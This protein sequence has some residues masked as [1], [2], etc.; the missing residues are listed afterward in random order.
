MQPGAA[1][2][3]GPMNPFQSSSGQKAGCNVTTKSMFLELTGFNPHPARR[4]DATGSTATGSP[5]NKGFNPHPARR[6]DA[7]RRLTP[8]PTS[9]S[10][11]QSSSGQKAGCN[12][13]APTSTAWPPCF[14]PHPARRPDATSRVATTRN[15]ITGFNPHPARRPD[16][17]R[18]ATTR[19]MITVFQS[20]S[21]QKAGCN[22]RPSATRS[23]QEGVSILIRPEGRMQPAS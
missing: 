16:A 6:P 8:S 20:S 19:N 2:T 10:M 21:G 11:F 1:A 18:V 13:A 22:P 4:P 5:N 14:N 12:P 17:T 7:T 9:T 15:M 23:V 3:G